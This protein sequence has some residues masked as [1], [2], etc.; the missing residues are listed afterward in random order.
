MVALL[1]AEAATEK[2]LW[3]VPPFAKRKP[4]VSVSPQL[5]QLPVQLARLRM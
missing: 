5:L 1:P 2:A 4:F 3:L